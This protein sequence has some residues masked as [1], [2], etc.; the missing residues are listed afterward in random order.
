MVIDPNVPVNATA[1]KRDRNS[2][3]HIYCELSRGGDF[4]LQCNR[5]VVLVDKTTG[6]KIDT[7][8]TNGEKEYVVS[9]NLSEIAAD[10]V[11]VG[12][13]TMTVAQIAAFVEALSDKYAEA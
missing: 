2:A 11:T 13:V 5:E 1:E 10:T 4:L 3:I 6:R 12:G 8:G 7:G 9:K